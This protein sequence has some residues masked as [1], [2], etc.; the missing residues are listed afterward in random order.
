MLRYSEHDILLPYAPSSRSHKLPKVDAHEYTASPININVPRSVFNIFRTKVD[1]SIETDMMSSTSAEIFNSFGYGR[2]HPNPITYAEL[3]D[4]II[5]PIIDKVLESGEQTIV[6]PEELHTIFCYFMNQYCKS[7]ILSADEVSKRKPSWHISETPVNS[8]TQKMLDLHELPI[9]DIF[10][11]VDLGI[12]FFEGND[13]YDRVQN[14]INLAMTAVTEDVER[15]QGRLRQ[16]LN[17]EWTSIMRLIYGLSFRDYSHLGYKPINK[18]LRHGTP[19]YQ[20]DDYLHYKTNIR[21]ID[22]FFKHFAPEFKDTTYVIRGVTPYENFQ[23]NF[24]KSVIE[25]AYM[26]TSYCSKLSS[27]FYSYNAK[28][29]LTSTISDNTR[30]WKFIKANKVEDCCLL[31]IRIQRGVKFI[32][33]ENEDMTECELLLPRNHYMTIR[34]GYAWAPKK[35]MIMFGDFTK[36][37]IL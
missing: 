6:I 37:P 9:A 1:Q 25:P 17:V 4:D 19:Q 3:R 24:G 34:D 21:M 14:A 30:L 31:V 32:P 11:Q 29:D 20:R 28:F 5:M 27:L 2:D 35:Q 26:S 10:G 16:K 7:K 15:Q 33:I 8:T 12:A 23:E 18:Y 22:H 36:Q 13:E